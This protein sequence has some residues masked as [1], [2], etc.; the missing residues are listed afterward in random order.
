M[1]DNRR[2]VDWHIWVSPAKGADNISQRG[3]KSKNSRRPKVQWLI[4]YPSLPHP[5]GWCAFTRR[6]T[7][8]RRPSGIVP[9]PNN[10]NWRFDSK[11][12]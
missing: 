2:L 11:I 3:S 10:L 12:R 9:E 5:I 1:A 7:Q 4:P 6:L 8:S